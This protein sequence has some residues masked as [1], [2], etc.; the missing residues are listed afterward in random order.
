MLLKKEKM[1]T[2]AVIVLV[3]V[4]LIYGWI[5]NFVSAHPYFS[6]LLGIIFLS[7]MVLLI[8]YT[9]KIP[10]LR[11]KEISFLNFLIEKFAA[12]SKGS[13]KKSRVPIGPEL[14]KKIFERADNRCQHCGEGNVKLHIH[15]INGDPSNNGMDN[16]IALCPNDHSIAKSL[17][18]NV[19]RNE[20]KKAYHRITTHKKDTSA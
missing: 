8:Y 20:A 18:V 11:E 12:L 3:A 4:T 5:V 6:I 13:E 9:I 14:Q 2:L 16:L 1:M 17:P 15:H 19:L 7:G 10:E